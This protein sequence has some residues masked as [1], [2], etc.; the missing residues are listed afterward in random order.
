MDRLAALK[1]VITTIAGIPIPVGLAAEITVPLF[2]ANENLKLLYN[3]ILKE[4]QEKEK[5][6]PA[7]AEEDRT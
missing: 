7:G 1:E 4:S 6:T 5:E 3:D 2:K